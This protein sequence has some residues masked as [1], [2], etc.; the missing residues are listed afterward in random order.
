MNDARVDRRVLPGGRH[1]GRAGDL[2]Q[3]A[4]DEDAQTG[5]QGHRA[6]LGVGRQ[7]A[8]VV[9]GIGVPPRGVAE[10]GADHQQETAQRRGSEVGQRGVARVGLAEYHDRR[11]HEDDGQHGEGVPLEEL[12]EVVPEERDGHLDEHH[13]DQAQTLGERGEQGV[14]G[15]RPADA[16]D[17]EPADAG[18]DGVEAGGEDVADEAEA[19][20]AEHHLA[21]AGRRSPGR[22]DALRDRAERRADDDGQRRLARTS[23]PSKGFRGC[24]PR[25]SRT[26]CWVTTR[27]RAA[28]WACR[29]ARRSG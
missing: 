13:D 27:S 8:G 17:G 4:G 15:Q 18:D 19:G 20:A 3:P 16:V 1:H 7:V 6:G 21:E 23:A 5:V 11:D 24:P 22:E 28:G 26:P 2:E 10:R 25:P 29:G 9:G 12:H 14:Q